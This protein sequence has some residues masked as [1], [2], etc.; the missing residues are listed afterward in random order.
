MPVIMISEW[1]LNV[2]IFCIFS[3]PVATVFGCTYLFS[4]FSFIHTFQRT[5]FSNRDGYYF[6]ISVRI[7]LLY[8]FRF[9]FYPQR[10]NVLDKPWSRVDPFSPPCTSLFFTAHKVEHSHCS[11]AFIEINQLVF[12][13]WYLITRMITN[14][15]WIPAS[16]NGRS[17]FYI[18]S[19]ARKQSPGTLF[20]RYF[21]VF[22]KI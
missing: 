7:H 9:L 15:C 10:S 19:V 20:S 17:V 21:P 6:C 18:K 22:H 2:F 4:L 14:Q 12:Y 16:K 13:T 11:S 3:R 8:F 5:F 1:F